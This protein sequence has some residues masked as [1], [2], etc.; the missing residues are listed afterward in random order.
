MGFDYSK[1]RIYQDNTKNGETKE[2]NL[3]LFSLYRKWFEVM[4]ENGLNNLGNIC[5][6]NCKLNGMHL[7]TAF[8]SYVEN[9]V[10]IMTLGKEAH[11]DEGDVTELNSNYQKD[12]YYSY[13]YAIAH[14]YDDEVNIPAKDAR[15]TFYLK[16][17]KI[18][19][20]INE[21]ND[22]LDEGKVLSILNNNLNK[23]S[24]SGRWTPCSNNAKNI[25]L[26]N[27]NLDDIIY[28][29]FEVDKLN[30]NIFLHEINILRPNHI[31][32][33]CGKGYEHHIERAFGK[34]FLEKLQKYNK[35]ISINNPCGDAFCISYNDLGL[36]SNSDEKI[37]II[38]TIHPSARLGNKRRDY[39]T[40]LKDFCGHN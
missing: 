31:I 6:D 19:S 21:N 14:R 39:H 12:V 5:I 32:F 17:R 34:D 35:T 25:E 1:I 3:K 40:K 11:T 9:P 7:L 37:K 38:Q 2:L 24:F 18:I 4:H 16:A 33:L 20:G 28:S 15:N 29:R 30:C 27:S 8:D 36:N 13:D 10:R 22:N 23:T 26:R